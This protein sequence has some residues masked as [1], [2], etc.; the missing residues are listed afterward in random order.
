M[1]AVMIQLL[2]EFYKEYSKNS[3]YISTQ[4]KNYDKFLINSKYCVANHNT[5]TI[6]N[7]TY[8]ILIIGDVDNILKRLDSLSFVY[9][10]VDCFYTVYKHLFFNHVICQNG[11]VFELVDRAVNYNLNIRRIEK[12][13]SIA[14]KRLF[15]KHYKQHT[16]MKNTVSTQTP[17]SS[18]KE[19]IESIQNSPYG[20]E[21][22]KIID[23]FLDGS[24]IIDNELI[25]FQIK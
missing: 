23:A 12:T 16:E 20:F 2:P 6:S 24:G 14:K 25:F 22:F 3:I 5:C 1:A 4:S 13:P 17:H 18:F 21:L 7:C 9:Q 10:S 15:R 19:R 8:H 11:K